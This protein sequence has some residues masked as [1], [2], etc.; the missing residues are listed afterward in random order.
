MGVRQCEISFIVEREKDDG[1]YYIEI[2]CDAFGASGQELAMIRFVF[3]HADLNT[4][5]A[6]AWLDQ[7]TIV[8]K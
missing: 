7:I 6:S 3:Q 8:K 4:A 2:D 5:T 1:W